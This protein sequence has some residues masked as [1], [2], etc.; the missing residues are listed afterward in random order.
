MRRYGRSVSSFL[1]KQVSILDSRFCRYDSRMRSP[2]SSPKVKQ[3]PLPFGLS[4]PFDRLRVQPVELVETGAGLSPCRSSLPVTPT[5][6]YRRFRR[7]ARAATRPFFAARPLDADG[8]RRPPLRPSRTS[9]C[10]FR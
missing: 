7:A 3:N 8:L 1:R 4:T 6:Y 2:M 9:H 10:P 5:M